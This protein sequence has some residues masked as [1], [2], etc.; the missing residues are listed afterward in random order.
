MAERLLKA[1]YDVAVW[2][3]TKSKA[4]SRSRRAA[5]RSSGQMA[6]IS[7]ASTCS[8]R[9]IG[10]S[11]LEEVY[12]GKQGVVT[13]RGNKVPKIFVDCSTIAVEESAAFRK[14]LQERGADF[15]CA[16]VSGNAK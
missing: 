4:G 9:R 11:H 15:V 7:R 2:N 13:N 12:F 6:A 16:P 8:F 10:R 5:P 3:R 14:R 1:G